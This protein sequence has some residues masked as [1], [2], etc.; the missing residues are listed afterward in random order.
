MTCNSWKLWYYDLYGY[1]QRWILM[2]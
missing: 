2:T 1:W